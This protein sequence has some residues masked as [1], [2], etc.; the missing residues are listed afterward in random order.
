MKAVSDTLLAAVDEYE[1]SQADT[2]HT[3]SQLAL[4][5]GEDYIPSPHLTSEENDCLKERQQTLGK[6]LELGL[7]DVKQQ[8]LSIKNQ[9][10]TIDQRIDDINHGDET[11]LA[12]AKLDA[13]PRASFSLLVEDMARIVKTAQQKV[14][15]FVDHED[16]IGRIITLWE[17]WNNDYKTF[18]TGHRD[19]FVNRCCEGRVREDRY[20]AW[21]DEWQKKRFFIEKLFLPIITFGLQGHLLT[22]NDSLSVAEQ[23]LQV[24]QD[25]KTKLDDFYLDKRSGI[26]VDCSRQ[27]GGEFLEKLETESRL[28]DLTE[29]FQQE[30]Q[31][32]IFSLEKSEERVYLLKWAAPLMTVSID[33]VLDFVA[34]AHLDGISAEILTQFAAMK[35][36]NFIAF[37]ADGKAYSEA[38]EKRQRGYNDLLFKMEEDLKAHHE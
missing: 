14:D 5:L 25:F 36:Q 23:A 6:I 21:L 13:E 37:L 20:M 34:D 38:L 35:H 3:F 8:L 29:Q 2:L 26:Y 16:F 15:F 22:E 30:L 27:P 7:D 18:K 12:L 4:K 33:A 19:D 10:M 17:D 24:L 32:I 11:I 9:A 1:T 31:P 28:N